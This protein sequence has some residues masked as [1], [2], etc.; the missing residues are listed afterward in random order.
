MMAQIC[1]GSNRQITKNFTEAEF[2]SKSLDAPQC[3]SLDDKVIN[4]LQIIRDSFNTPIRITSTLRTATG[5]SAVGGVSDSRHL[6]PARAID[7]QPIANRDMHLQKFYDDFKC[8]GPL[9]RKLRASGINGIGIYETFIH[10]DTRSTP[11]FWD[12]SAGKWGDVRITNEYM[13]QIPETG[14]NSRDCEFESEAIAYETGSEYGIT[15]I[16]SPLDPRNYSGEDG[17]KSQ[18]SGLIKLLVG[19]G[20][21]LMGGI[22][23]FVY[24]RKQKLGI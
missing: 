8:K 9:Y 24:M 1:K 4:G 23:L 5:N 20:M 12:N 3:H 17:I 11:S 7:S 21:M 2:H 22:V 19:G 6:N 13:R 14:L 16:L 18:E 15:G 10:I